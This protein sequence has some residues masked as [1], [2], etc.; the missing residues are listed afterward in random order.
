[1]FGD[2]DQGK[3]EDLMKVFESSFQHKEIMLEASQGTQDY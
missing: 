2:E 3:Y 1:M